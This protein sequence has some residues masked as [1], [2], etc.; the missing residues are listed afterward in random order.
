MGG[1]LDNYLLSFELLELYHNSYNE[2]DD[3]L[4]VIG[5]TDSGVIFAIPICHPSPG[6]DK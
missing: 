5:M 1:V 4:F 2:I 3:K 6:F